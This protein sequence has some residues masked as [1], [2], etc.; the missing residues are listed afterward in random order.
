MM[1]AGSLY[2]G[3]RILIL[4]DD[5][6]FAESIALLLEDH[7]LTPV[8]PF[9]RGAEAGQSLDRG[10]VDAAILDLQLGSGEDSLAIAGRLTSLA[11]PFLFLTGSPERV[12]RPLR[13]QVPVLSKSCSPEVLLAAIDK[14]LERLPL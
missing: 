8:G 12:P 13:T 6:L 7:R 1:H 10:E 5:L 3:R 14:L 9:A 2:Q 4:E 11:I